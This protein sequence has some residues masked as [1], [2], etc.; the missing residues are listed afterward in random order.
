MD[1]TFQQGT[2]ELLSSIDK[3]YMP[4]MELNNTVIG[5]LCHLDEG[6]HE[7]RVKAMEGA[8][9]STDTI[10]QAIA[11]HRQQQ[12]ALAMHLGRDT[13]RTYNPS[14]TSPCPAL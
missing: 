4:R 1:S 5:A 2:Q 10:S 3:F 8:G 13:M 14:L 11:I 7:D 6:Y 9:L 12:L